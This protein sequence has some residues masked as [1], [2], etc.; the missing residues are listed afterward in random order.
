MGAGDGKIYSC[1][2]LR[3]HRRHAERSRRGASE[4]N[5]MYFS[6]DGAIPGG[7]ANVLATRCVSLG[8]GRHGRSTEDALKSFLTMDE[9][10]PWNR[11]EER[12]VG[13]EC[14]SRW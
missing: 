11:S 4:S 6:R 2:E 1:G 14:R 13:K 10:K 9:V 8:P 5:E 3:H 12:R 7:R